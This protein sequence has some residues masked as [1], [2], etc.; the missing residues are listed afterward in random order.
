M[1][2]FPG[3]KQPKSL[4][5]LRA[6][7]DDRRRIVGSVRPQP[8]SHEFASTRDARDVLAE[9]LLNVFQRRVG[10]LD[11]IVEQS[12]DDRLLV[13]EV[14]RRVPAVGADARREPLTGE[15]LVHGDPGEARHARLRAAEGENK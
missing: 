5:E 3:L 10:V 7:A 8:E 6:I 14:I 9:L 15:Q 1:Q 13:H 11:G 2:E 12:D 4:A